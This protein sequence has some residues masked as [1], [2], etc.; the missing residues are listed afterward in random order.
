[1][2]KGGDKCHVNQDQTLEIKEAITRKLLL[3][4]GSVSVQHIFS[5][6]VKSDEKL[7]MAA[8]CNVHDVNAASKSLTKSSEQVLTSLGLRM[9]KLPRTGKLFLDQLTSGKRRSEAARFFYDLLQLHVNDFVK[10]SQ[11]P[12]F[13]D[14]EVSSATNFVSIKI[15]Q[16]F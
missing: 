3:D 2:I 8:S 1:L 15:G 6:N 9:G 7:I 12:V 4:N 10:L 14:V 16:N 13:G 11:P 5:P